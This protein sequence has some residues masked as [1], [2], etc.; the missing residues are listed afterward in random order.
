MPAT[1]DLAGPAAIAPGLDLGDSWALGSLFL[2]LAVL[3][4]IVALTHQRS[5]AFSP[6]VVYLGLG[7]A[8][9]AGAALLDL[10]WLD[11]ID[12]ADAVERLAELAV[13]VALFATGMRLDRPIGLRA[14]RSTI[15]LL[16][17]VMPITIAAVAAFGV[18]GD[19]AVGRRRDRPGSRPGPDRSGAG[20]RPRRRAA[21]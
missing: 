8:G 9:A 16:A 18:R 20:R 19:G 2:G 14:W 6:S 10:G 15:L 7:A 1:I 5:R 11:L 3:V 21:R 4:A 12:D 13:I 17:V